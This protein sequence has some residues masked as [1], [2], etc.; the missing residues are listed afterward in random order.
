MH[1][2]AQTPS[3][4]ML[5][6]SISYEDDFLKSSGLVIPANELQQSSA[7]KNDVIKKFNSPQSIGGGCVATSPSQK[8]PL[9]LSEEKKDT[10]GDQKKQQTT[11]SIVEEDVPVEEEDYNE[12]EFEQD[13]QKSNTTKNLQGTLS[14]SGLPPLASGKFNTQAKIVIEDTTSDNGLVKQPPLQQARTNRLPTDFNLN[15]AESANSIDF[16]IS[17]S[18]TFVS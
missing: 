12:D 7:T 2:Q 13:S 15:I 17:D 18:K 1:Q 9:A 8:M 4:Q 6:E 14:Q 16:D 10:E 5:A 3:K 11:E